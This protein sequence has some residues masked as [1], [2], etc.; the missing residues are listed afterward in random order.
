MVLNT[1]FLS[2]ISS[3]QVSSVAVTK[4]TNCKPAGSDTAN[5][6][7]CKTKKERIKD[8]IQNITQQT[9]EAI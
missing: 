4:N 5:R 3:I 6:G 1:A 9:M 2:L 8:R 7:E